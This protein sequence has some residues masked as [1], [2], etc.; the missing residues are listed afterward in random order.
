MS[1]E[2]DNH[3]DPEGSID[4]RLGLLAGRMEA[5]RDDVRT[6]AMDHSNFLA[7]S[8]IP[9]N[10]GVMAFSVMWWVLISLIALL[11]MSYGVG[12]MLIK[13]LAK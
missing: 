8:S 5:I 12:V 6:M 10:H 3:M 1:S 4:Y 9:R 7:N 13:M 11:I 2:S